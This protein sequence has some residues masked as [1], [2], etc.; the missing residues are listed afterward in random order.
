MNVCSTFGLLAV[1]GQAPYCATKFAVRGFTDSIRLELMDTNVCV[2]LVCPS[3]VRTN[4]IRN[5]RHKD[6]RAKKDLVQKFDER[7]MTRFTPEQMAKAIIDGMLRKRDQVLLGKT[8][9]IIS[10]ASQI[11]PRS[12]IKAIR[13]VN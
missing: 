1:P 9:R 3:K 11:I 7:R 4:I 2:T 13:E 10:L 6:E 8:A 12:L 5:A